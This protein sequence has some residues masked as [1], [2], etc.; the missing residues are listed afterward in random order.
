MPRKYTPRRTYRRKPKTYR[1]KKRVYRR[2]PRP[3]NQR[4]HYF[5]RTWIETLG[6]TTT[7]DNVKA[8]S[9]Q[10][11]SIPGFSEFTQLYDSLCIKGAKITIQPQ[12]N[13]GV[14]LPTGTT[15][16]NVI[17]A[18]ICSVLDFN[19]PNSSP[20]SYSD[21]LQYSN[22]KETPGYKYHG[23]YFRPQLIINTTTDTTTI[24]QSRPNQWFDSN[25]TGQVYH[26]MWMAC[27]FSTLGLTY[28]GGSGIP[29]Q[30][31]IKYTVY[32]AAKLVR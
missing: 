2:V 20:P 14:S 12:N 17:Q 7:S 15:Y 10:P 11:S 24:Y 6:I 30:V 13:Q 25:A 32:I 9:F 16:D 1:K 31:N 19:S 21:M 26:G 23:R 22:F 27:P 18:P 29:F 3:L 5:K 4:I 8:L 28:P